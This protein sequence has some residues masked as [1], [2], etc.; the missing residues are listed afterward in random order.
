M[1]IWTC[2]TTLAVAA[3]IA[4]TACDALPVLDGLSAPKDAVALSQSAMANGAFTLVAPQG[5]C[6]DKTSL[7]QR[8]ALM[9]RCDTLGAPSAAAAA[10][11]GILTVSVTPNATSGAL[12]TPDETADAAKL[13][14]V[15]AVTSEANAVTFRAEGSPPSAGL[16]VAHW[17]GTARI[18]GHLIG[19]ALYGPKDGRA[20]SSEGRET[21]NDMIRRTKEASPT[22]A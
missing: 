15:T 12:P 11:L 17:R 1:T 16:G 14:R 7:K 3:C 13:A 21:I 5:F 6:I 2:K 20:I 18:G 9:A 4:L 22:A 10:P 8:F 19:I